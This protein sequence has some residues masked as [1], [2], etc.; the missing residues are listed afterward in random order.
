VPRSNPRSAR[1][2]LDPLRRF[3]ALEAAGGI[4]LLAAVVV[5]LAW[6]SSP[7]SAGYADLWATDLGPADLRHWVDDGL[8]T[9][10]FFVI[11]LEVR[12]E[13]ADGRLSTLRAAV[14]PAVGALG[15]MVVPAL[16]YL[17][18]NAGGTGARGWGIPMATD[19]AFA[20]GVLALLGDRVPPGLGAL[21]LGLA[22]VDD[23]GAIVVI[24]VVYSD[25]LSA[26]WG[27]LAL[28]GLVGVVVLR[29]VGVRPIAAYVPLGLLVWWATWQ[30]GVHA[31]IAG[32]ALGLLTPA[33]P[34]AGEP[35]DAPSVAQRL[36]DR[37]HPWTTFL[38]VPVFAL[39]GAGVPLSAS[40]LGDAASSPVALGVGVGLVVGKLVGVAG[41]IA[42][43][44]RFGRARLPDGVGAGHVVGLGAVAGIGFTVSLFVTG[45][46]F[47]ATALVDVAKV[48]ILGGSIVAAA[49][50]STILL[51]ASPRRS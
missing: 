18:F 30:S 29:R 6:A 31:T 13:L 46:A 16:L 51:R 19:V 49:L 7:W 5:A 39:A 28:A 14:V 22:V 32:V 10:F 36:Q 4:V 35:A 9:L 45:L 47:D 50:G 17:A 3:V 21:L 43:A 42:L 27:A 37:L 12:R 20:L 8:M 1:I 26:G 2:V 34:L 25:G 33:R 44:V 48:G 23:I 15:G 41:A 38:V 40:A 11:G 24:A